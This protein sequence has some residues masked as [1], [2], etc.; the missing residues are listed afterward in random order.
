MGEALTRASLFRYG[1]LAV[2]VA[3]AGFPLYV[4][5]PDYFATTHGISL[6][7][8]GGLLLAL[9][10]FDAV[11][12]PVIGA[13][14]DRYRQ[15]CG[16]FMAVAALM[17]CAAVYGLFNLLPMPPAGWFALCVAVAVAGYSV[18]SINLNALGG[19][20]SGQRGQ[21]TRITTFREGAGLVGLILAVSLPSLLQRSVSKADAYLYY[22]LILSLLMLAAWLLFAPWLARHLYERKECDANFFS[23]RKGMRSLSG[24]TAYFLGV[25]GLSML[26]SSIPAVLVIFFVRDL[27]QA[28]YLTGLFLLLYF[29]SGA[30]AMPLWQRTAGSRGAQRAWIYA[31][32]LAVAS[33]I[34]AFFLREG[35]VWLYGLVCVFSGVALGADLALPP[36]ILAQHIHAEHKEGYASTHYAMLALVAKLSLALASAIA[37]PLLGLAGFVPAASNGADALLFLSVSYA[38]IPCVLKLAAALLL[39]RMTHQGGI[40]EDLELNRHTRSPYHA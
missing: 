14:S 38:L 24:R 29:L 6:S 28:E 1:L 39:R 20:W 25:Y 18:L 31:M 15:Y 32:L 37:L 27:L 16:R 33:F 34:G 36:A 19:L 21:Q 12:D 8:L 13:L 11:I 4:L 5:A 10:L 40:D 35:D 9:R 3:F 2:P 26:A 30:L 23:L 17:L 22:S 7:L